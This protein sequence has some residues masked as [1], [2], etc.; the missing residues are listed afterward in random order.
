MLFDVYSKCADA[1][2]TGQVKAVTTDNVI[3]LGLISKSNGAFKLVGNAFTAEPYGIGIKKGDLA[4]CEF[5][6]DTLKKAAASGA[7]REGVERHRG[8]GRGCPDA[9]P[10]RSRPPAAEPGP[11]RTPD[12]G[13][14][15]IT[16][17]SI[18]T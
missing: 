1:L 6:N 4:F 18:S 7:L 16:E 5:I 2:R 13:M 12:L 3:L 17:T 10:A 9:R 15:A 11:Y 8:Q 14:S